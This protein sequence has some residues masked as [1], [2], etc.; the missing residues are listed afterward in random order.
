MNY[1]V[2]Q[3]VLVAGQI[4]SNDR[5]MFTHGPSGMELT[6]IPTNE[7][8]IMG[9]VAPRPKIGDIVSLNGTAFTGHR[10]RLIGIDDERAWVSHVTPSGTAYGVASRFGHSGRFTIDYADTHLAETDPEIST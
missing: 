5:V 3:I 9:V 4:I 1:N 10:F 7:V 8:R 6:A 2:G